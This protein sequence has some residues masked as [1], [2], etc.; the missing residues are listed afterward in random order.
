MSRPISDKCGKYTGRVDGRPTW[1]RAPVNGFNV[2]AGDHHRPH[3]LCEEHLRERFENHPRTFRHS[4]CE[5]CGK[6][7]LLDSRFSLRWDETRQDWLYPMACRFCAD[8]LPEAQRQGRV[9]SN[10]RYREAVRLNRDNP[11]RKPSWKC[12]E[13]GKEAAV[14]YRTYGG[15][16]CE[17]CK[18]DGEMRLAHSRWD[19]SVE[20]GHPGHYEGMFREFDVP[21]PNVPGFDPL[22]DIEVADCEVCGQATAP[23]RRMRERREVIWCGSRA[24]RSEAMK[25]AKRQEPLAAREC[26]CGCGEWFE[27]TRRDQRFLDA[28]HRARAWR[29]NGSR[30]R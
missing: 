4:E 8:C 1:C 13:C 17:N 6:P 23:P 22:D 28:S 29:A 2:I 19:D 18:R 27:P 7:L 24:C 10:R 3:R 14:A 5:G 30:G 26:D 12:R 16:A 15:V 9:A 25:L 11:F 20:Q 21:D